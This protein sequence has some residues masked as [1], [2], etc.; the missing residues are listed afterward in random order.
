MIFKVAPAT[1]WDCPRADILVMFREINNPSFHT[2]IIGRI[3]RMPEGHHYDRDELNKAYIY[4]NY[5]KKHIRDNEDKE[6]NKNKT[7]INFSILKEDIDQIELKT[8]YH[9]RTDYNS[10]ESFEWQKSFLNTF[11]E[12]FGTSNDISKQNEN[13]EIAKKQ[14]DFNNLQISNE[15]IVNAE[16][17]SFDNFIKEIKEKSK[18]IE[19]GLSNLDI[20]RM[21]NLLCFKELESQEVEEAKYCPSRS[22]GVL[23]KAL[24]VYFGDRLGMDSDLYYKFL[25]RELLNPESKIKKAIQKALIEFRKTYN[26]AIKEKEEKDIF[27]LNVP[28]KEQCFSDD[29]EKIEV[30]KNVYSQ[31]YIKKNYK[32]KENELKFI[33]FID[34]KNIDWWHKQA[35][36]GRDS[37]AIEY[38]DSQEKTNRLFYPDFVIKKGNDIY[39]LDTKKGET[40]KSQNTKDKAEYLQKWIKKNQKNYKYNLIG[41]I[42]DEKYPNWIINKKDIYIYENNEDWENLEF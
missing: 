12:Y 5:N 6:G 2:Q 22:W 26:L 21:Y 34:N 11:H 4:T 30:N 33:N 42:A 10:L 14:L 7:P 40:A 39:L 28:P 19:F 24:N 17:E 15:I 13:Y 38:Y 8:T 35:D 9:H 16:I 37:F 1:G 3:K 32:G 29:F 20:Q 36:S 25:V 31:F 41:G 23:K 27:D 18:N